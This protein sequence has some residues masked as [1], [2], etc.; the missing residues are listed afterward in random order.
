MPLWKA[1]ELQDII[2]DI[3]NINKVRQ[4]IMWGQTTFVEL[5]SFA[6]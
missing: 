5:N 6:N 4:D 2:T 1:E 3:G